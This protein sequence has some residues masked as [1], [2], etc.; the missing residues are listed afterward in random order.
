MNDKL[1]NDLLTRVLRLEERTARF[2]VGTVSSRSPIDVEVADS[3]VDVTDVRGIGAFNDG[4]K[5]GCLVSGKDVIVLGRLSYGMTYGAVEVTNTG[6]DTYEDVVIAHN[7][8]VAPLVVLAT[9]GES[10]NAGLNVGL[11]SKNAVDF[12]LRLRHID[13][14]TWTS[15]WV[16]WLAISGE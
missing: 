4:S 10:A 14:T 13:A 8:S 5:V 3:G 7:L 11:Q 12:T 1:Y 9:I 16:Y 6:G 2:R 15:A